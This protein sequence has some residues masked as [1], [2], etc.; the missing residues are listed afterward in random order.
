MNDIESY[1][2]QTGNR[3][4]RILVIID[5]FHVLFD[6][7][8]NYKIADKCADYMKTLIKQGRSFG[9]NVLISSQ[10]IARLHDTSLD[11][12][13]YAQM[14]VRIAL[15]CD[16]EDAEFMFRIN[17]KVTESFGSVKGA[18]AYAAND[19]SSPEKFITAFGFQPAFFLVYVEHSGGACRDGTV[20]GFRQYRT[21]YHTACF[22]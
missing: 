21:L 22:R 18:G 15:K 19:S 8:S 14:A 3:M 10:G 1:R 13:L 4:P 12:G 7:N 16:E 17:P 9:I 6:L 11:S 2:A 5:E 20:L